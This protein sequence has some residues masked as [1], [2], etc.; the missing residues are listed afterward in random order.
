VLSVLEGRAR[1]PQL[2][3]SGAAMSVAHEPHELRR[4]LA[5]AKRVFQEHP[6][7][8]SKFETHARVGILAARDLLRD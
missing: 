5:K 6:V 8:V 3:L 2:V 1:T 7:V 4:I